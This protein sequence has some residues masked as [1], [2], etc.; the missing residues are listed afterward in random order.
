MPGNH[1]NRKRN[2][3]TQLK[4]RATPLERMPKSMFF[5]LIKRACDSGIVPNNIEIS[6]LNWAHGTG[7][8]YGAGATLSA[9]DAE[10]LRQCYGVLSNADE[11]RVESPD[12]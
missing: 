2:R 5:R 6:T 11:I 10:L 12:K 7:R 1:R 9:D 8:K 3:S 4:I